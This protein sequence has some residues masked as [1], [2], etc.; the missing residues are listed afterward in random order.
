MDNSVFMEFTLVDDFLWNMNKEE[1]FSLD[2]MTLDGDDFEFIPVTSCSDIGMNNITVDGKL[3][4]SVVL[5]NKTTSSYPPMKL[6]AQKLS[7]CGVIVTV[8]STT[9]TLSIGS[10]LQNLK[11]VFIRHAD[12]DT[13]LAYSIMPESV[14]I[15]NHLTLPYDGAI[16]ELRPTTHIE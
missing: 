12:T 14:P 4:S 2:G 3:D 13:I 5:M 9:N 7:P 6:V 10:D 15:H 1:Y 8:G 11:G 16:I